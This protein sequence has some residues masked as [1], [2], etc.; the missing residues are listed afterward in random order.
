MRFASRSILTGFLLLAFAG[1]AHTQARAAGGDNK[2]E[3]PGISLTPYIGVNIPTADLLG[4]GTGTGS[5]DSTFKLKASV[6]FGGRLGIGLTQRLGLSFDVGYSP[7]T[8][9]FGQGGASVNQDVK[10]LTGSGK[11]VYFLIPSTKMVWTNVSAGVAVVRHTVTADNTQG[12]KSAT[13]VGGVVGGAAGIKFGPIVAL[14]ASIEDY[15]YKATFDVTGGKS[16][17]MQNDI[18]ITAGVHFPFLGM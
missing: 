12:L 14:T 9:D 5:P 4:L 16:S 3:A 17:K 2:E 15:I 7:G 18:R 6:T 8:I 1:N 13:N 11:V 10:V